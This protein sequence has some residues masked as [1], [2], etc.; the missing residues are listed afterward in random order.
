MIDKK[1]RKKRQKKEKVVEIP[2]RF[3]NSN[4]GIPVFWIGDDRVHLCQTDKTSKGYKSVIVNAKGIDLV[5]V[6]DKKTRVPV[7]VRESNHL[8]IDFNGL[9]N[10]IGN[11]NPAFKL[12]FDK[13]KK[14]VR[15]YTKNGILPFEKVN[16]VVKEINK[17]NAQSI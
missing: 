12:T 3:E 8:D 11:D 17:R 13:L 1:P 4:T 15:K 5:K 10:Y 6:K 2:I 16:E 14:V 9:P 7:P